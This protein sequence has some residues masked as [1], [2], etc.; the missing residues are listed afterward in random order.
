[1]ANTTHKGTVAEAEP[2]THAKA[3]HT[4][5]HTR[6][7]GHTAEVMPAP[8]APPPVINPLV[9]TSIDSLQ[10]DPDAVQGTRFSGPVMSGA[11]E[12]GVAGIA[13]VHKRAKITFANGNFSIPI[14]FP[15]SAILVQWIVQIQQSY[16]GTTPKINLGNVVNGVDI[17]SVDVS[18]APTQTY[19]NFGILGSSWTIW[20]SQVLGGSTAGKCTVLITY[21]VP[22][23]ALPD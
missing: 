2:E 9:P 16:N 23:K 12:D 18:V 13:M 22:A 1:M 5:M 4:A 21:S 7:A 6:D 17:T 11:P 20:L 14:K 15:A 8:P 10:I 19:G 3:T